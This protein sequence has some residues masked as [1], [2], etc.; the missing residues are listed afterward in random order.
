MFPRHKRTHISLGA[1]NILGIRARLLFFLHEVVKHNIRSC[2]QNSTD[3]LQSVILGP[4]SPDILTHETSTSRGT[5]DV[6]A[7]MEQSW[8]QFSFRSTTSSPGLRLPH[9]CFLW[10]GYPLF[11]CGL[12]LW[13]SSND[14][15]GI[16]PFL[17]L[18]EDHGKGALSP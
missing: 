7:D 10:N 1:L 18:L 17:F 3:S 4:N 8:T 15:S 13:S 14:H 16:S 6:L 5:L 11:F 12:P 9:C 2:S